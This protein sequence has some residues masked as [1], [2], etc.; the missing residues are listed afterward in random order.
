MAAVVVLSCLPLAYRRAARRAAAGDID[1]P[2]ARRHRAQLRDGDYRLRPALAAQRRGRRPRRR[3]QRA[4]QTYCATQRLELV[5]RELLLDT[6]VQNTPVAMLLVAERGPIVVRQH[7]GAPA[8]QR[9]PAARGAPLRR[10]RARARRARCAK[11]SSA[12]A[13]GSSPCAATATTTTKT[14]STTSRGA[15]SASTAATTSSCCCASSRPSCAGR[16]CRR[17]RR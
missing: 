5:R 9:R 3:A 13:T 14:T 8:A 12:A 10:R 1:V 11:R 7:R 2:R 16:R 4:R 6:M 17:G 15:A